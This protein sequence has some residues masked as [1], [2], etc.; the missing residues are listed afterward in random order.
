MKICDLNCKHLLLI[1]DI[2]FWYE[3]L[4]LASCNRKLR[5]FKLLTIFLHDFMSDD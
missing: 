3:S 1:S 4:R 2:S 5:V